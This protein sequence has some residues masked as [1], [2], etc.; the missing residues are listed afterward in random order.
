MTVPP[1]R[2]PTRRRHTKRR[3]RPGRDRIRNTHGQS[4]LTSHALTT[5]LATGPGAVYHHISNKDE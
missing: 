2:S 1:H 4:G 3:H 5:A